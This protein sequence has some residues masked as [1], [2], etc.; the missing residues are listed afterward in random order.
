MLYIHILAVFFVITLCYIIIN[1]H[2]F[3]LTEVK[4]WW[5]LI[6]AVFVLS[7]N[8]GVPLEAGNYAFLESHD[9]YLHGR[10]G[11]VVSSR[12]VGESQ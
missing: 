1:S 8:A 10:L 2:H 7:Y 9:Q 3:I 11:S 4:M 12:A 6:T 5:E